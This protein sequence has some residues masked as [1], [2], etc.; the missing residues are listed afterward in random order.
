MSAAGAG[1]GYSTPPRPQPDYL[2]YLFTIAMI[3]GAGAD[4][5]GV[6]SF[7]CLNFEIVT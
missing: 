5:V 7:N 3:I 1:C 2:N 6:G 4:Y